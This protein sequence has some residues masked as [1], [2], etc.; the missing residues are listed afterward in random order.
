MATTRLLLST[1]DPLEVE[2]SI[3][4]VAKQLENAARSGSGTLARLKVADTG[5]PLAINAAHVV[6][7]RVGSD[8]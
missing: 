1:G 7:I 4:E 3:D 2:G 8:D 6:A 5:E